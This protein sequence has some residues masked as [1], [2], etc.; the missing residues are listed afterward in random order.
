MKKNMKN[1]LVIVFI[2]LHLCNLTLAQ[3]DVHTDKK[4]VSALEII[5][6]AY[7]DTVNGEELV[8]KAIKAMLKELDPHSVYMSKKEVEKANEPLEGNFEGVGI[9][10][11]IYKDTILVIAAIPG[12]PS[13]KLGILPGDKIIR[14]EGEDAFGEDID[15][16]FVIDNLRGKRGSKVDVEIYR[17]G[18]E[19][20][21]EF[22]IT[23]DKIPINSLDAAF[24]VDEEVGYIKINRFARKTMEEYEKA[25]KELQQK[26]MEHLILDLRG[27][28]G[29]YLQT[30][31]DLADDYI[32][33]GELILYTEGRNSARKNYRATSKGMFEKGRLIVMIDEGSASASEI[34]SGAVQDLDRGL[35]IGRRSFGKGLVQRPYMLPDGSVIRLTTARYHT[36]SGRCIQRPYE[37]GKKDYYNDII[38]RLEHGELMH[39]DSIHFPDS[40]TFYTS[41]KRIVYGGGGVMPDIFVPLD[42]NRASDYY[43]NLFRKNILNEFILDYMEKN[44]AALSEK[45]ADFDSYKKN[46]TVSEELCEELYTYAEEKDLER[47]EDEIAAAEIYIKTMLKAHIARNLF[48]MN[49]YYEIVSGI[50]DGFLRA[51]EM[52]KDQKYFRDNKLVHK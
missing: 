52:I 7:V 26:G 45:Y 23:R 40:L 12:G 21:L 14:I 16:Q 35:I 27:N 18:H 33:K 51:V 4:I 19:S 24:M 31:I 9:Q 42:T 13:D 50:D 41:N 36:P 22:T 44:R 8:E 29:G 37:N 38:E 3:S 39:E 46:F 1:I 10:F 30:S 34:V 43:F 11:Q 32:K 28:A 17:K 25:M 48:E 47:K 5:Q 2:S 6:R 20:L 49:A 15:N